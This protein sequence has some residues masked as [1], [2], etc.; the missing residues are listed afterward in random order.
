MKSEKLKVLNLFVE[1]Q[2]TFFVLLF[3]SLKVCLHINVKKLI[4]YF[5]YQQKKLLVFLS[6]NNTIDTFNKMLNSHAWER[7]WKF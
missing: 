2:M 3:H 6:Q 4:R 5:H 1:N 7:G